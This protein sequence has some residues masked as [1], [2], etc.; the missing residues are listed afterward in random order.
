[1]RWKELK[2]NNNNV[3]NNITTYVKRSTSLVTFLDGMIFSSTFQEMISNIGDEDQGQGIHRDDDGY[4]SP[5]AVNESEDGDDTEYE[6]DAYQ[7]GN[8][9]AGK[10][11]DDQANDNKGGD[12]KG[13]DNKGGDNKGGD[14]KGGDNKGGIRKHSDGEVA[15]SKSKDSENNDSEGNDSEGNDSEGNDSEGSDS[16]SNDS[17]GNDSE[18]NDSEGNDSE[19]NDRQVLESED[20]HAHDHGHDAHLDSQGEGEQRAQI[21]DDSSTETYQ[22]HL[23]SN[24]DTDHHTSASDG[25]EHGM[26]APSSGRTNGVVQRKERE[27]GAPPSS[28][29]PTSQLTGR[30]S[31]PRPGK[32]AHK[33]ARSDGDST[34]LTYLMQNAIQPSLKRKLSDSPDSTR[35]VFKRTKLICSGPDATRDEQQSQFQTR[36]QKVLKTAFKKSQVASLG[37]SFLGSR[38][39]HFQPSKHKKRATDLTLATHEADD[40]LWQMLRPTAEVK[41]ALKAFI[42]TNDRLCGTEE[43]CMKLSFSVTKGDSRQ[44]VATYMT[45]GEISSR[46]YHLYESQ[47]ERQMILY[48]SGIQEQQVPP[49]T[50]SSTA[51]DWTAWSMVRQEE[52]NY[53]RQNTTTAESSMHV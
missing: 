7:H 49:L 35:Q 9:T 37:H 5:N 13:G 24:S 6:A 23:S 32:N 16:E 53:A 52:R 22:N 42:T 44:I 2:W 43:P 51:R 41:K 14:N 3:K 1:M 15:Y 50:N 8:R 19:S 45:S 21:D 30:S 47:D 46:V 27:D 12:N 28:H 4:T 10:G 40:H 34:A 11:E 20:D 17:E 48:R 39:A 33:W 31:A 25:A 18:G 38:Q 36:R 29:E 26:N